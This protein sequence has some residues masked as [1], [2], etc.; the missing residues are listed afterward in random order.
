MNPA[1]W[2][3]RH[4]SRTRS[5]GAEGVAGGLPGGTGT[6]AVAAVAPAPPPP[7]ASPPP[8]ELPPV[9]LPPT[10]GAGQRLTDVNDPRFRPSLPGNLSRAGMIV[11]GLFRI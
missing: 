7:P 2:P 9:M 3:S 8:R 1:Q 5:G 10:V 11:W 4:S 6:A